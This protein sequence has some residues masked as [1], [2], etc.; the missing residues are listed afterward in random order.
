MGHIVSSLAFRLG[1]TRAWI[2][3]WFIEKLYYAYFLHTALKIRYFCIYFFHA[4]HYN[5][6]A[7]FF[8]HIDILKT[9]NI[10]H[11]EAF[12]YDGKLEDEW[13]DY[14][15]ELYIK[16]YY[17]PENMDP[18][19]RV[20]FRKYSILKI[21][22]IVGLLID[23]E[24]N[25]EDGAIPSSQTLVFYC[26]KQ[27]KIKII[28]AYFRN[29]LK[30]EK[31][32]F[33]KRKYGI[34][35]IYFLLVYIY[36]KK[37]FRLNSVFLLSNKFLLIKRLYYLGFTYK[38]NLRWAYG[39]SKGYSRLMERFLSFKYQINM[40]FYL[41]DNNCVNSRFLSR[42]IARK[43]KQGSF[44]KPL[45]KPI[46][47]ELKFLMRLSRAPRYIYANHVSKIYKK[48]K[49]FFVAKQNLFITFLKYFDNKYKKLNW[50]FYEKNK[51]YLTLDMLIK[52]SWFNLLIE[53]EINKKEVNLLNQAIL[54]SKAWLYL[55]KNIIY[56]SIF[57]YK[58]TIN[59]VTH[60]IFYPRYKK[61]MLSYWK[62]KYINMLNTIYKVLYVQK[63]TIF[64][65]AS[66]IINEKTLSTEDNFLHIYRIM[67]IN[68]KR[69]FKYMFSKYVYKAFF[70]VHKVNYL[71]ARINYVT[72]GNNLIGY[73]MKLA[74]RFSRKQRAGHWW[75][76]KGKA[77]LNT[78]TALIDYAYY[79]LPIVN[80]VISVRIWLYKSIDKEYQHY[81]KF[82]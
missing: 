58:L 33:I 68:Y 30:K 15:W 8:S 78:L 40:H 62:D 29:L 72:R 6:K 66:D 49:S 18:E 59:D 28:V 74:G 14:K 53:N 46:R 51:I 23:F 20:S 7:I 37:N 57:E 69:Y 10:F 3:E 2:D 63:T 41:T 4:R 16:F 45:L 80:S 54:I 27:F 19:T 38:H 67:N 55:W 77:P 75:F 71:R 9:F 42:Y 76:S 35:F 34:R 82:N 52:A 32:G 79:A 1:S 60:N 24:L 21:F 81:L 25:T 65:Y 36:L 50:Y 70:K 39:L 43:L 31:F 11:I 5:R 56:T 22:N 48:E 73:K 13:E 26:F 47:K 17:I 64:E 44:L 61:A 12:Y